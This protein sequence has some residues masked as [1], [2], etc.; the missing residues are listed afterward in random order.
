MACHQR[1]RYRLVQKNPNINAGPPD[2]NLWIVHYSQAEP[3][4]VMPAARIQISRPQQLEMQERTFIQSQGQLEPCEFMLHD[5]ERWPTIAFTPGRGYQAL[6]PPQAPDQSSLN[7]ST[8]VIAQM[9]NPRF[10]G[11]FYQQQNAVQ[12][13]DQSPMHAGPSPAKRQRTS[14]IGMAPTQAGMTEPPMG[15]AHQIP[16][17]NF[18]DTELEDETALGDYLDNLNQRE[19]A[20]AR[21]KQHHEWMEEIISSPYA[22][23]QIEPAY[24]G[25][26]FMGELAG[27]TK[28]IFA[29]VADLARQLQVDEDNTPITQKI[30]PDQLK[31]FESR[32]K[33]LVSTGD[34][35]MKRLKEDHIKKMESIKRYK[36]VSRALK[37]LRNARWI[38]NTTEPP[39]L[40]GM[41]TGN[42]NAESAE[43][44]IEEVETLVGSRVGSQRQVKTIERGGLQEKKKQRS[45]SP[46]GTSIPAASDL[47]HNT[48]RVNTQLN[49]QQNYQ[50]QVS[51]VSPMTIVDALQPNDGSDQQRHQDL[52]RMEQS[53]GHGSEQNQIQ[54]SE[55][56]PSTSA[57]E[58]DS[59]TSQTQEQPLIPGIG[60]PVNTDD[61]Q[62]QSAEMHH[63]LNNGTDAMDVDPNNDPSTTMSSVAGTDLNANVA[64]EQPY[65][66]NQDAPEVPTFQ[67]N[68]GSDQMAPSSASEQPD[69]NDANIVNENNNNQLD[70]VEYDD[71][72]GTGFVED[73]AFDAFTT[74][75]VDENG[76]DRI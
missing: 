28:G 53:Q 52:Q 39:Y 76:T 3:N 6:R 41:V 44:I 20:Q 35:E 74:N 69:H 5:R 13:Q 14:T 16:Y 11:Q 43:K 2:P 72:L 45:L 58:Q 68:Q 15:P 64:V 23:N 27:L 1:R 56:M 9:G 47:A 59:S 33:E 37:R 75:F 62:N 22:M 29:T 51:G 24:L 60:Q 4:N 66:I 38:E 31:E 40:S 54:G 57:T 48:T 25:F 61:G 49:P 73:S 65:S 70:G 42:S 8:P 34:E 32:V 36:V 46:P 19:V 63:N 26:G 12:P 18:I 50:Q 30:L 7:T 17:P 55:Q 71:I 10:G 21:F 67:Q